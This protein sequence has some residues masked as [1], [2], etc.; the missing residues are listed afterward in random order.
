MF[1]GWSF[2]EV[3]HE[4][5]TFVG[6]VIGVLHIACI[7]LVLARR[8][9]PAVTLAWLLCLLLLPAVGVVLFWV[10]GRG[11]VR[12]SARARRALLAER[13]RTEPRPD[14]AAVELRLRPL[15]RTSFEAG[16]AALTVGNR[17][18]ILIDAVQTYPAKLE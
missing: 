5:G 7:P 1:A 10:F 8:R 17:I 18:E 9:E 6:I 11:A 12:R 13:Q 15:V 14:Y 16:R 2:H 3:W 4:L